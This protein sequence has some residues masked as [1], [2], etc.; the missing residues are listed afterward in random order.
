MTRGD[1]HKSAPHSIAEMEREIADT[2]QQL[3][4]TI[5]ELAARADVPA[6]ARARASETAARV[7]ATFHRPHDRTKAVAGSG[8]SAASDKAVEAGERAAAKAQDVREQAAGKAGEAGQRAAGVAHEVARRAGTKASRTSQDQART[9][10]AVAALS[11]AAA[12]VAAVLWARQHGDFGRET[13]RV[14][15]WYRR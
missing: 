10:Y 7:R 6:R 1:E 11:L 12:T 13:S 3:G 2:R 14:T 5:E 8:T 15:Y 9:L 4:R